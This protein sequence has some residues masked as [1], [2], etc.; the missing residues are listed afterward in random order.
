[1]SEIIVKHQTSHTKVLVVSALAMKA[2]G[3]ANGSPNGS[4]RKRFLALE[5]LRGAIGPASISPV[6]VGHDHEHQQDTQPSGKRD[7]TH[8][9]VPLLF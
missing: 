1:M 6:Y 4:E 8:S 2:V 7:E 5:M 9:V 3:G